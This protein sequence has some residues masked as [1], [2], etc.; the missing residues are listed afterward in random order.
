MSIVLQINNAVQK[1]ENSCTFVK[2]QYRVCSSTS[3]GT[4]TFVTEHF[5]S[6]RLTETLVATWHQLTRCVRHAQPRDR[7]R[8]GRR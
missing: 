3:D 6:A 4:T 1:N 2:S 5:V 8:N 7:P